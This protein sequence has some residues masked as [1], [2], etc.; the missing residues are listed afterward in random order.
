[1]CSEHSNELKKNILADY[2]YYRIFVVKYGKTKNI[3]SI[4]NG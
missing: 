3:I 2:W 4:Q 1:M